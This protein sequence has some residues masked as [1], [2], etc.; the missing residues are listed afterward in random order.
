MAP[1][2]YLRLQRRCLCRR[3]GAPQLSWPLQRRHLCECPKRVSRK[4]VLQ[5]CRVK[6]SSKKCQVR[7]S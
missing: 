6:A 4:S 1:Q 2:L 5:E 7:V 3:P